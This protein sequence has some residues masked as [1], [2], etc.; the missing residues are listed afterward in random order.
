V[1]RAAPTARRVRP[2][3][4]V[5]RTG[6]TVDVG[7]G[8]GRDIGWLVEHGYPATGV[9]P[10]AGLLAEA[11]LRHPGVAFIQSGLPNLAG[12]SR[13]RFANVFCETVIMHLDR[14]EI[15]DAGRSLV[16]LLAPGGTIYLSWRSTGGPDK[17]DSTGR[18]HTALDCSQV[19]ATLT[20]TTLLHEA[21]SVS[22]SSDALVHRLVVRST[23]LA[24]PQPVT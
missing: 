5:L 22:A 19:L 21:E 14:T 9:D 24:A 1:G 20:N 23:N 8:G 3:R 7:C 17:R 15:A 16:E 4:A 13:A 6:P 11:R 2:G 18:L 12:V 10:S